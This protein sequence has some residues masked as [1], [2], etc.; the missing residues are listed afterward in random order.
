MACQARTELGYP[1]PGDGRYRQ[2][3]QWVCWWHLKRA[4]ELARDLADVSVRREDV[5]G[6]DG[7]E[8]W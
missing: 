4:H 6:G 3:E 7:T 1:C 2:D 8:G 5:S